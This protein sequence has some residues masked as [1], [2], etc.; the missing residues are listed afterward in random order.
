M[1]KIILVLLIALFMN[2][3]AHGQEANVNFISTMR[4]GI[5]KIK[6]TVAEIEKLTGQKIKFKPNPNGYLDT[7]KIKYNNADY[8]LCFSKRYTENNTTPEVKELYAVSS[9]NTT[10]KTKSSIGIYNTKNEILNKYDKYD[11]RIN[12]DWNFKEKGNVKDKVQY[13]ILYDYDAGT[14]LTFETTNRVVNLVE[15]MLYEGE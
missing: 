14:T 12:N 8:I 1:K 7:A 10:L 2:V 5:F 9:T 15:V 11:L 3:F 13:I 6:S 4:I